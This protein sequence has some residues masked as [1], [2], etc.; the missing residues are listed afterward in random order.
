MTDREVD[1][2]VK[3]DMERE[4]GSEWQASRKYTFN[5]TKETENRQNVKEKY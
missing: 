2:E 4:T 5:K 3:G 1:R